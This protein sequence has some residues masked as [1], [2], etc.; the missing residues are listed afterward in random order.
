MAYSYV[1]RSAEEI[2]GARAISRKRL[3]EVFDEFFYLILLADW[4]QETDAM[5]KF[6]QEAEALP[7]NGVK[8]KLCQYIQWPD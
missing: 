7:M 5:K 8:E 2:K 4:Y 6:C 1:A 3:E